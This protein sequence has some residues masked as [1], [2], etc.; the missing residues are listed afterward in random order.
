MDQNLAI[1]YQQSSSFEC[2]H[3]RTLH[4]HKRSVQLRITESLDKET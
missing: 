2:V 4:R 3:D 1:S